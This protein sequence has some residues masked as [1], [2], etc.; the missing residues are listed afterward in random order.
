MTKSRKSRKSWYSMKGTE[1]KP[2]SVPGHVTVSRC[3]KFIALLPI[4]S[5]TDEER[6]AL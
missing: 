1:I 4:E 5:L 3:G 6:A 2:S